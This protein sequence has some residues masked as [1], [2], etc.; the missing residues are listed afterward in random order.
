MQN[1]TVL[2]IPEFLASIPRVLFLLRTRNSCLS[3]VALHLSN[4]IAAEPKKTMK[5]LFPCAAFLLA[6][7][8]LQT[9]LCSA[10]IHPRS[11]FHS[12]STTKH[13][14]G[15]SECSVSS[16][17]LLCIRG[18]ASSSRKSTKSKARS[19][20]SSSKKTAT[21]RKR[22]GAA[23]ATEKE[24][25]SSL[26]GAM[27]KYKSILPLTRIYLTMVAV[28]NIAGLVL[29]D[30]IAQGLFSFNAGRVLYGLELWRPLTAVS[31]LGPPSL[32]WVF[33]TY[34]VYQYGS[35]LERAYGMAQQLVFLFCQLVVL[36]L[37]S[38]LL[39]MP[40]FTNSMIT[41]MLY[42]LSRATPKEKV[43]WL[44]MKVPY[45]T[46]PYG[47]M[48]AD[49]FQAGDLM[50]AI[51]HIVGILSGHFFFFHKFIWPKV[52]GEDWLVAPDFLARKLDPDARKSKEAERKE[53]KSK[54]RP[55]KGRKLGS[56]SK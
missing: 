17:N 40:F 50:A 33:N 21:G 27:T 26:S 31:Y 56:G 9:Q 23:A 43:Q 32:G 39:G 3:D 8:V 22:V 19:R 14:L 38:G 36:S 20:N 29:G 28:T 5:N 11:T 41:S 2:S 6:G 37:C 24:N 51:P 46:L 25:Q 34:Y 13:V 4:N 42:V 30:E 18:G 54:R 45:W 35:T 47:L 49:I 53:M 10:S 55:G 16:E 7:L 15:A 44:I 1:Y 52:G 48:I 12:F